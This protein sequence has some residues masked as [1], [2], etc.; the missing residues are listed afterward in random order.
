MQQ[1]G[2]HAKPPS[3]RGGPIIL[4]S[5]LHYNA[6]VTWSLVEL[7][8]KTTLTV[9]HNNSAT[10]GRIAYRAPTCFGVFNEAGTLPASACSLQLAA[11]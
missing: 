8:H 11:G 7:V 10:Y 3:V 9:L 5:A 4:N 6:Q 1:N 2:C